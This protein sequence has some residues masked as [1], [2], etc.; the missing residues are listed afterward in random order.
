MITLKD[1]QERVLES[2]GDFFRCTAQTKTPEVAF[3]EVTRR[4]GEAAPYFP[5]S[6]AG[7]GPDM[8]YVCLRVPTGGRAIGSGTHVRR[9]IDSSLGT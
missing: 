2:L 7:L 5:V 9:L 4:F 1:Y 3:R 8:P 6:A